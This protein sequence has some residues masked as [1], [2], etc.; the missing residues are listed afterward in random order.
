MEQEGYWRKAVVLLL[1][2]RVRLRSE[3]MNLQWFLTGCKEEAGRNGG[4]HF[5]SIGEVQGQEGNLQG[6][7]VSPMLDPQFCLNDKGG[8]CRSHHLGW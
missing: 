3:T 6:A 4:A 7:P 5:T 8:A 1:S 2:R